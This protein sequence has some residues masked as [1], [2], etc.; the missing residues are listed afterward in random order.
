M[1]FQP[2]TKLHEAGLTIFLSNQYH[3]EIGVAINPIN[4]KTAI[5]ASTRTGTTANLTTVWADLPKGADQDG[6][7]LFIKAEPAQYSLG[8]AAKGG[9]PKYIATV[10]NT[11]LQSF[12]EGSVCLHLRHGI[13]MLTGVTIF[14]LDIRTLLAHTLVFIPLEMDCLSCRVP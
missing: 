12:V 1:K 6:V 14:P 10:A 4:N 13:V 8:Y 3:N 2:T 5:F 11:W 9:K 7:N